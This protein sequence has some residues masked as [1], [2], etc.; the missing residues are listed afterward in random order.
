[1]NSQVLSSFFFPSQ[2]VTFAKVNLAETEIQLK[3]RWSSAYE[4]GRKQADIWDIQTNFVYDISE[5][6]EV[7]DRVYDTFSVHAKYTDVRNYALNRWYNFQSAMAVEHIFNTHP[8]V[9]K[10]SNIKDREKDFYINGLAFDHEMIVYPK[11][12]GQ[13]IDFA[14]NNPKELAKWL[15]VNKSGEQHFQ[16]QN[17]LFLVLYRKDGEHWR[18]KAEIEWIKLLIDKYMEGYKESSLIDLKHSAGVVKTDVI[19]GVHE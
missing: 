12:F 6:D 10:V 17:R 1:M 4:W 15:Y 5:F 16:T 2:T 3:K 9:R 11:G 19:F 8:K 13:N 14:L 7:L 18:L